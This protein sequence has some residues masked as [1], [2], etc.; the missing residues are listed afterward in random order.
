M[1]NNGHRSDW[2]CLTT[3][4]VFTT[5]TSSY[6]S[7]WMSQLNG[8][9]LLNDHTHPSHHI[10]NVI[11]IVIIIKRKYNNSDES[12]ESKT[13]HPTQDLTQKECIQK[14]KYMFTHRASEPE[15]RS[16]RGNTASIPQ[17]LALTLQPPAYNRMERVCQRHGSDQTPVLHYYSLNYYITCYLYH[18]YI[19]TCQ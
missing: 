9:H 5:Y 12:K 4:H 10:S 6:I 7:K 11:V 13:W 14:M 16:S 2:I 8:L 15:L 17:V 1:N 3:T 19:Y 18:I